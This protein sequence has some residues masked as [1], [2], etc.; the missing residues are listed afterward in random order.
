MR[1]IPFALLLA[2][3]LH[4]A[5][6][7]L[8][9]AKDTNKTFSILHIKDDNAFLCEIKMQDN[10]KDSV[11]C[12]FS[13]TITPTISK[14]ND[15][16]SITSIGNEIKIE[17]KT[18]IK[19]Q[20]IE[21]NFITSNVINSLSNTKQKHWIIVAYK[22]KLP[23]FQNSNK[24]G[25]NFNIIFNPIE[26]PFVGSLDLDGL[27]IIQKEDAVA[28]GEIRDSYKQ[29]NLQKVIKLAD[30][31]LSQKDTTYAH[32]EKLYK[33]RAMDKLAWE[34]DKE[35]DIDTD[36]LIE[37]AQEWI[38]ENP[39]SKYLPEVL[40]YISKTYYK[41]GHTAKGDEYSDILKDEFTSNKFNLVAQL[42]KADRVYQNRKRRKEALTIYK[43]VLYNTDDVNLASK[44]ASKITEKY[45][46]MGKVDLAKEFY[47]KVVDANEAYIKKHLK[48]S[49]SFAKEFAQAKKYD[50]A[51]KIVGLLLD[52][53]ENPTIDE[54]KKNIGY[55]YELKGDKKASFDLYR[56]YL[57]DYSKGE[58]VGFVKSRLD[59]LLLDI[60]EKNETKKIANIDNILKNYQNDP[61]YK[62]ALIEK[63]KILIQ[64][65][66][67][68]ELFALEKI[69]KANGGEKFLSYGAQKKIGEDLKNDN[70][71]EAIYLKQEYNTTIKPKQ[72]EKFFNCLMRT[73]QYKQAL[74]ITKKHKDEKELQKRLTWLYHALKAHS[75]LD[76][77]KEVIMIGEDIEKLSIMLQT[78][79]YNDIVYEK[80]IAYYNLQ[81]Y[82]DMMLREVQKVEKFFPKNIKNI[83]LFNK[84]LRYAKSSK[85]DLLIVNYT[86]K[87]I[88]LQKQHKI[89][90]YSPTVEIDLVN[91]L[92]RLKQ[93]DKALKE[94]V[95]LLYI[96]LTDAQRANVLF[97][98][99]EL[100]LRVAK[101]KEAKEFF[102]KCGEIVED[103]S[104]QRLCAENLKLLEE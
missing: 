29:K 21:D 14:T 98:A 48:E 51:I 104:W 12:Q 26:L 97:L 54:M 57:K 33:L 7:I 36:Q 15:D 39:S 4:S 89:D 81:K 9:E 6:L 53:K 77:N 30:K 96:K 71:K 5:S 18:K 64:N 49:Y 74:E 91:A 52:I 2:F 25:L 28:M 11:I 69:L 86:K 22:D 72:Q 40:M 17:P 90:D 62:K 50:I 20:A 92:K 34:Q 99:G 3:H 56:Q 47:I 35:S 1:N 102:I 85:N 65:G 76:H 19:L 59:K 87:I 8:N 101:Q 93:Y 68:K 23:F 43:D 44:A 100:S 46:Q 70:C 37:L 103:S 84:V 13:K 66:K 16:L 75:K 31:E 27:P 73:A 55:W 88:E 24:E 79:K 80:A 38:D 67:Y 82:D 42:H 10:F 83:D 32:E 63:A 41:R 78:I 95:K 58:H 61:I 94:D 45:L 60:D